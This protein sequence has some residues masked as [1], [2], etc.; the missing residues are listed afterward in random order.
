[1][2]YLIAA[3]VFA[4]SSSINAAPIKLFNTGVDDAGALLSAGSADPHY[5]VFESGA[6]A[7]VIDGIPSSYAPNG[8][9]S[10]W[11]WQFASGAPTFVTR[12]FRTTFDLTG[13]D[14]T[15]AMINGLWGTDNEGLDI[16]INGIST[17]NSLLG[18]TVDN[19]SSLHAFD[20][21]SGFQAGLNT[22]DFV[23][24]DSGVVS[25]FRAELSGTAEVVPE[26]SIIALMAAGLAGLGFARRRARTQ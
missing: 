5:T 26:P 19:F 4:F 16:L 2:K 17:G 11:I 12:T 18:I 20:I 1:M 24:S 22:I 10:Q 23:I 8:P 14:H 6:P 15:T 3:L 21:T 25:G 13:F 9:D 7:Q